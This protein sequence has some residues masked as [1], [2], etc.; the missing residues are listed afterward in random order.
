MKIMLVNGSPHEKG[1]TN[2]M[3]EEAVRVFEAE[4]GSAEIF[5]IGVKPTIGCM[6]CGHCR[7]AGRCFYEDDR[8]NEF[9]TAASGADGF[10][11]GTPVYYASP[12][13]AMKCFMD[14]VFFSA[15][16]KGP[17][18][19]THKP[20][21]AVMVA[22]RAGTTATWDDMNKYFGISQMPI[23]SSQ[24]WNNAHGHDASDVEKDAEGLQILRT[25]ARNMAWLIRC[26]AVGAAAGVK[27]P[28]AEPFA[29]TNFIR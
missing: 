16:K 3:L 20:A 23:V 11:F 29:R 2:R 28:E 7:E 9:V 12:N 19:F 18:P 22:R 14:R 24:Y 6:A 4:G 5:H 25:L 26:I 15:G 10:I 13:G 27:L 8:V 1:S 21:A 17:N